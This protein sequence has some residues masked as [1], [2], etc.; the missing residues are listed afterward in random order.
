MSAGSGEDVH[1]PTPPLD[2]LLWRVVKADRVGECFVRT[3][4][5]GRELRAVVDGLLCWSRL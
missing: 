4:P 3:M 1:P 5:H 2:H